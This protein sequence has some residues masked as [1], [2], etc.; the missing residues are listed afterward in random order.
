VYKTIIEGKELHFVGYSFV[1]DT[2]LIQLGKPGEETK[3]LACRMQAVMD[4]R[5]GGLRATSGALK[6]EKSFWYLIS[7]QW[8]QGI[9]RYKTVL[10]TLSTEYVGNNESLST[11]KDDEAQKDESNNEE[12]HSR[13][14][15]GDS[16][17]KSSSVL[18]G[19]SVTAAAASE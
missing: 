17:G 11:N 14:A 16:F 3:L 8:I 5:E 1:D 15:S 2:D 13:K 4:T 6:P 9:W 10:K 12:I 7:F 18:P 19:M